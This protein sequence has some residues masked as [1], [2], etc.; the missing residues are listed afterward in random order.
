MLLATVSQGLVAAT[1][2]MALASAANTAPNPPDLFVG[3]APLVTGTSVGADTVQSF[4]TAGLA[5]LG[6]AQVGDQPVA[7]AVSPDGGTLYVLNQ[8]TDNLTPVDT[9]SSPPQSE[10][11]IP[12]P[13][14][15]APQALAITPDGSDAYVIATSANSGGSVAPELWE[16]GLVGTARGTIAR[17]I[18]LPSSSSPAGIALTPDGTEALITN[19]TGGSVIPVDLSK[20]L[21]GTQIPVGLA[22]ASGPMGIAV[23]PNGAD[24]FVANSQDGSLSAI[25]L[26][27]NKVTSVPLETDYAPV[28]VA[29][30]PDGSTVWASEDPQS[31][32]GAGFAVPVTTASLTV[33]SPIGIGQ[34]PAGIA[35]SPDGAT[36]YVANETSTAGGV[37][38]TS[39]GSVSVVSTASD[40]VTQT[41]VTNPDPAIVLVTP[42]EAPVASFTVSAS[43]AGQ[44]TSFDASA[45][46]SLTSGGLHYTWN[47]G[48]GSTPITTTSPLTKHI[49]LLPGSY[50]ATLSVTDA[51]GT[52]TQVIYTGQYVLNNGGPSAGA[53]STV[54]VPGATANR[55]PIAYVADSTTNQVTPILANPLQ[56][57]APN[58]AGAPIPVG[59]HP[60]AIAITPN[61]RTAY[62]VNFG[63]DNV[64]PV[65]VATDTAAPAGS[66]IPV[67]SEPDAI[68][69]SPDG[70][71]AYVANSGDGTI[72]KIAL[73][74]GQVVDTISVGGS[75]TGIAISPDGTTAYVTDNGNGFDTVIPIDLA[76][77][78]PGGQI[79][80]GTDP[81]AIAMTPD[82]ATAY[83][84]DAGS[85]TVAGAVT[86]IDLTTTPPTPGAQIAVGNHP[87][88][89][90]ISP[91]GDYAYVTNYS[92]GTLSQITLSSGAT[93]TLPAG[94]HPAGITVVPSGGAV[95]V[96][97]ETS[98][99]VAS[100]LAVPAAAASPASIAVGGGP[101]AIAV[102]PDEAP[103]AALSVVP[104]A[105]TQPT[106]FNASQTTFPSSGPAS[107][108]W[109][110]GD[111]SSPVVT[112]TPTTSHVYA[113]GGSYTATVT[114]TDVDGTSTSQAFTGQTVTLNGGPSAMASQSVDVPYLLP[115]VS[116][117]VPTSG[118]YDQPT[119]LIVTGSNLFGVTAVHVGTANITGF[120]VN[121]A[122]TEISGI[123]APAVA[124]PE[125]VDVTVT[126]PAGTSAITP[127]DVFT[128]LP[129][130]SPS[131][132]APTI[133][134]LSTQSGPVAGGTGVT[135]VGTNL[136]G[137]T[138][139]DFGSLPASSFTVN[140]TGTQI[141]VVSPAAPNAESVDVS[142]TTP[143]GTSQVS[144]ADV[145]TYV[146]PA[147]PPAVPT[148]TSLSPTS[149][150]TSGL[151][152]VTL[153]G[154]NLGNALAVDFGS[155][156]AVSFVTN[157]PTSI[158]A[159]SPAVA[160]AG[161]VDVTV[162]TAVGTSAVGPS[163]AFTYESGTTSSGPVVTSVTP[164]TGPVSGGNTVIIDG[165]NFA[166]LAASA[167]T[168]GTAPA[169]F[170][171]NSAKTQITATAPATAS[172]G[173]VD[174]VVTNSL[175]SSTV[176][177]ADAYT[178][179]PDSSFTPTVTSVSP[180]SGPLSGGTPVTLTGTGLASVTKV[181]FGATAVT[182]FTQPG[183]GSTIDVTA[184]PAATAGTVSV[185][186]SGPYGT[187]PVAT[188]D[189]YTYLPASPPTTGPQVSAVSPASGPVGGGTG[190]TISGTGLS[191][192]S[193]VDF[194]G[195]PAS[196]Y[197][198]NS[199]GTAV[200]AVSPGVANPGS[201][202]VTVTAGGATSP[203]STNDVFTYLKSSTGSPPPPPAVSAVTPATGP[204]TGGTL[205]TVSG[206]DLT[207][208]TSV[209]FGGVAGTDLSVS[210]SG[211]S[212][213]VKTPAVLYSGPV[214]VTVT[215]PSGTSSA[216]SAPQFS[217]VAPASQYHP[218]AP[219]RVLDTRRP[220]EGGPFGAGVTRSL[221]LAGRDGVPTGATAVEVNLTVTKPTA[222]TS[223]TA[224]PTGDP[225]PAAA[226]MSAAKGETV[227]HLAEVPLGAGGS[228]SIANAS[229]SV[230]VVVDLEGYY[231]AGS[232]AGGRLVTLRP[233]QVV[234]S[235]ATGGGGPVRKGASRAVTLTGRGGVPTSG[236]AAVVFNLTATKTTANS[237][238]EVYPTGAR[239]VLASNLNW[240]KGTSMTNLVVAKLGR[241][242]S[243]E[244]YN[245]EGSADFTIDV[246]GYI[247]TTADKLQGT[248]NTPLVPVMLAGSSTSA[249]LHL[250]PGQTAGLKV[251]G[252]EGIPAD[253]RA[254]VLDV[255]TF[256]ATANSSLALFPA[257]GLRPLAPD[258]SWRR[259]TAR[260]NLVVVAVGRGGV[261][262]IS[263]RFGKVGVSVSIEGFCQ[264]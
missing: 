9:L 29:V 33:G 66:W 162:V 56:A 22:A 140:S 211:T 23:S 253:A 216:S 160:S 104:G 165:S 54:T 173:T 157:S 148:L 97:N 192:A 244:I 210:A 93:A 36:V 214:P 39:E 219:L 65:D 20:G 233:R 191:G 142:V 201:I 255:S 10:T 108:T 69:I 58:D 131:S 252:V 121:K 246:V 48:D 74:T 32:T 241:K 175:G 96:A 172:A 146:A 180:D 202:D 194:G 84:V 239:R 30:S 188:T 106:A 204:T 79:P 116:G 43:P 80:A 76:N 64:T 67:G 81:V 130:T 18:T 181:F 215:T 102:T 144:A 197:S 229:G 152:S 75:P 87:S 101:D 50:A 103:V 247:T 113:E 28:S 166:G 90:A 35:I 82:G 232:G 132:G 169:Q 137:A 206:S 77:D 208:A 85:P 230:E 184:P 221:A 112:T 4:D 17:S 235:A 179:L 156:P 209:H 57:G 200:T 256:S 139:V 49:Y 124:K 236:V 94:T 26:A 254:V 12:L 228:I 145:F 159:V 8:S 243:V 164:S 261:V 238:F 174:V 21:V 83:V 105:A 150:P 95:Y 99:G 19:Y 122:G 260:S 91:A 224:F 182:T 119:S 71:Y 128:Y 47:F 170:S 147:S 125:S 199:A 68:A 25:N 251:A 149:G 24:A 234:N 46:Y 63:S 218:L 115:T 264:S 117:V 185:T 212:L 222:H 141:T 227:A 129:T 158:T 231:T 134:S 177:P 98:P 72:D 92:D 223:L 38:G 263:N 143:G 37:G 5:S 31:G 45:S 258:L 240:A 193:A 226:T 73:A 207:G 168:F 109:D 195:V 40:S 27:T 171:V 55:P 118:Q 70:S 237:W 78:Q 196:S 176:T 198:V 110:F 120:V 16:V 60:D 186:V 133:T 3:Y 123:L 205:V 11:A 100:E 114:V 217:Y 220:G 2:Q 153:T 34:N 53:S 59:T 248:V 163:D 155:S 167:V 183:T 151:T 51:S 62:V 178:Y 138:A 203:V 88:A 127:A 107:Y 44:Y 1:P 257:G 86:P 262:D 111:G 52:S 6:S 15:Y 126:N 14:G 189:A 245:H 250:G 259:G 242:G 61:G 41:L 161:T 13:S 135:I 7:E 89:I 190:V 154:T 213:T 187:S 225:R 42:D 249:S 136:S